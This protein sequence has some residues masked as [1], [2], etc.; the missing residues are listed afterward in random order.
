MQGTGRELPA[1]AHP[2]IVLTQYLRAGWVKSVLKKKLF[3]E[4][5]VFDGFED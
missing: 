3:H 4:Y 5:Q 1:Q 2:E